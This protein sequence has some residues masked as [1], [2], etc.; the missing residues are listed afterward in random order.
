MRQLLPLIAVRVSERTARAVTTGHGA[1]WCN[2]GRFGVV[3]RRTRGSAAA[4][5]TP[6]NHLTRRT[7]RLYL[8]V[9]AQPNG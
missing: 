1:S 5:L 4:P 6:G 8:D 9:H 2:L 3:P 7:A